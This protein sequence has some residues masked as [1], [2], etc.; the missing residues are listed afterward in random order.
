MSLHPARLHRLR[1]RMADHGV[2]LVALGPGD[3][4]RY[5]AGW[6]PLADERPCLLLVGLQHQAVL[7]PEL[8]RA[9]VQQRLD[10]PTFPYGDASDPGA[11]LR[12]ALSA[13]VPSPRRVAVSDD[14]RADHLLLL[15]Q[16]LQGAEYTVAS[17]LVA[18]LRARKDPEELDRLRR[19]ARVAEVGVRAAVNAV[20]PGATELEVAEAA[21]SAMAASGAEEVPFV[22]VAF[23]PHTAFP[24]HQPGSRPVQPG[25]P[26]L[27]DLG[28]RVDGYCAD[29]TR[30][31]FLG[32][33]TA[34]YRTVHEVVERAVQAA[35]RACRP[36][37]PAAQVDRA[38]RAVVEEAGY[39]AHFPHRTG[40][41]LGLS[42]HELPSLHAANPQPL[43]E[44]MVFTIEPGVYL[45]GEFGV[46]LEE[47][48]ILGPS[49]PEVLSALPRQ[50]A[51]I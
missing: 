41:G 33:P 47:T 2:D 3:D 9:A 4:F 46:R 12:E 45:T 19:A 5:L 32:E 39:G 43:E 40:H 10:I 30:M 50:V 44:G 21:R 6:A 28:A 15:Q 27:V 42:V 20:R 17:R 25:E 1:G 37:L 23:G 11:A 18:E 34:R 36:G 8:N 26:V 38:A 29:I 24:H 31:A 7:V 51:V 48:V 14:L 13:V 49:G 22:V 16:H 35:L